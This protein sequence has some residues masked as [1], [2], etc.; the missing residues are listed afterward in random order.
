MAD[1]KQ[2]L[3]ELA[4]MVKAKKF[5]NKYY[6]E[7]GVMPSLAEVN[8]AK[9]L[10]NADMANVDY[11]MAV[12][13][14]VEMAGD[15]SGG[16]IVITGETVSNLDVPADPAIKT[17][18]AEFEDETVINFSTVKSVGIE[19]LGDNVI[20]SLTV[21]AP[22]SS[23]NT[24]ITV[25]ANCGT[26]T[27]VNAN[28]TVPA[29]YTVENIILVTEEGETNNISVNANFAEAASIE[30]ETSNAI[31][32]NN[33]NGEAGL[34]SLNINAENA[35]VTLNNKWNEIE[36]TVSENTLIVNGF[37]HIN[38]LTVQKGNVI[39]NVPRQ[40]D[41][42]G[43]I[44]EYTLNDGCSIDYLKKEVTNANVADLCSIGEMTLMENVARATSFVT[45]INTVNAVWK[46]N[47]H[48]VEIT[49]NTS[50][51]RSGLYLNRY[52]SSLEI[53]GEGTLRCANNYG[54]WNNSSTGKIVIN[55]GN[56]EAETHAVYA[57]TGVIEINGGSFKLTNAETA[58]RDENGNLRFL[59][60]CLDA[61]Y[62]SGKANIIVKGGKF[63]EFDPANNAS[64]G[65]GTNYVAEGYQ[66]VM[67]MEDGK[68]VYTVTKI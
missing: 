46:L 4:R 50:Q 61:N 36:A 44:G 38:K 8:A 28:V 41:I 51:T 27:A 7:K 48:N 15:Y 24:T 52:S 64:E 68:K 43:V 3:T 18:K 54:L 34:P 53:N 37:G 62:Q 49:G 59:I 19:N 26:I 56:V 21:N 25:S 29:P 13:N 1:K 42:A 23:A 10:S 17:V 31:T 67:S 57:Q 14:L 6:A 22:A 32:I 20:E 35:T 11:I 65:A 55:G 40:S 39:V 9:E 58:D 47:G 60:N 12:D 45:P 16:T 33:K 63:Y 30:T 5:V 66:S 2:H